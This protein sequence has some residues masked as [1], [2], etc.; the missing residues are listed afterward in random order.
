MVLG[1]CD[2]RPGNYRTLRCGGRRASRLRLVHVVQFA[3]HRNLG[4]ARYSRMLNDRV[5]PTHVVVLTRIS[6]EKR[7]FFDLRRP[8]SHVKTA[9]ETGRCS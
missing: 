8:F 1:A 4:P 7:A 5:G 3:R 6:V 9:F 2:H